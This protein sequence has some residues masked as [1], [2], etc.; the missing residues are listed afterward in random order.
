M[1]SSGAGSAAHRRC[2]NRWG[3]E[4]WC[5]KA[6]VRGSKGARTGSRSKRPASAN[7]PQNCCPRLPLKPPASNQP[8]DHVSF[9][10]GGHLQ[11]GTAAP[12]PRPGLLCAARRPRAHASQSKPKPPACAAAQEQACRRSTGSSAIRACN[13]VVNSSGAGGATRQAAAH[14]AGAPRRRTQSPLDACRSAAQAE[15]L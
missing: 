4:L 3:R 7:A 2:Q 1:R 11:L 14:G 10:C 15:W 5:R 9:Q 13:E 12:R 8:A 6:T